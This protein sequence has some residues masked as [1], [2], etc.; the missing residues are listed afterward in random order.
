MEWVWQTELVMLGRIVLAAVLAG[1]VG[2]ER[3]TADKPAGMRTHILVGV[4]SALF[5]LVSAHGF[6]G[7]AEPSRIAAQI[8]TGVGFLGAGT[9]F[10]GEG[11]I[12][13][14]TTAATIWAVAALGMAVGAGM[15]VTSVVATVV[16]YVILRLP[17]RPSGSARADRSSERSR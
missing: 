3:E 12:L 13:G 15:Y 1:V 16:M 9:I 6:A 8:V 17:W 2:Y 7:Q 4:G 11:F 14:L 5:T 10:R